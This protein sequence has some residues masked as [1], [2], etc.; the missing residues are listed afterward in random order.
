M[1]LGTID[2]VGTF[3][4]HTWDK[5]FITAVNEWKGKK[6]GRLFIRANRLIPNCSAEDVVSRRCS[7]R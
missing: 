3:Y 4:L 1:E 7:F 5:D 6:Y 2:N